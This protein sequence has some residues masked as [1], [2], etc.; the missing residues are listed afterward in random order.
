MDN[1]NHERCLLESF[2]IVTESQANVSRSFNDYE[3]TIDILDKFTTF[4]QKSR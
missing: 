3:V 4:A 1:A 2:P